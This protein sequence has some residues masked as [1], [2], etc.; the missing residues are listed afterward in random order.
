MVDPMM[1]AI[2]VNRIQK[3]VISGSKINAL[4]RAFRRASPYMS[5]L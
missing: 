3:M 1:I 2:M 4:G 5:D